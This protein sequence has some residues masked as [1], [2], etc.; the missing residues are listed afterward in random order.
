[1]RP[2]KGPRV[3]CPGCGV[4]Y[5]ERADGRVRMHSRAGI[6][7]PGSSRLA[8]CEA[9]SVGGDVCVGEGSASCLEVRV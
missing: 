4:P 5:R 3:K 2:A 6:R 1:M 9:A 7:C 8:S